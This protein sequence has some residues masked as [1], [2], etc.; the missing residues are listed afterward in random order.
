M[1]ITNDMIEVYSME[2]F[3]ITYISKE[4]PTKYGMSMHHPATNRADKMSF[5]NDL[6]HRNNMLVR[7]EFRNVPLM[8]PNN[9]MVVTS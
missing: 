5:I 7:I 9:T 4:E 8:N 2:E 3:D 1:V 6:I